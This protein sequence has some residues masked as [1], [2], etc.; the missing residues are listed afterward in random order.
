[1]PQETLNLRSQYELLLRQ[2]AQ[3]SQVEDQHDLESSNTISVQR[4]TNL[5][6]DN[7]L[8]QLELMRFVTN[9]HAELQR[10]LLVDFLGKRR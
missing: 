1:M 2:A 9:N 3:T 7:V 8:A 6:G 5:R 4:A 10:L